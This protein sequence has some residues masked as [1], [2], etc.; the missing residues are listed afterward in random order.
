[1]PE[2]ESAGEAV[3]AHEASVVG[4]VFG[5]LVVAGVDLARGVVGRGPGAFSL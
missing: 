3:D 1:M 4:D 2:P 5:G